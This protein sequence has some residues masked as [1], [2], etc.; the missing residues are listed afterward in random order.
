ME[1]MSMAIEDFLPPLNHIRS[2]GTRKHLGI[3]NVE[4]VDA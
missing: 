4:N 1:Y 2:E 3:A